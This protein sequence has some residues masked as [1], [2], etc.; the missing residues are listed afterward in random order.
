MKKDEMM[1]RALIAGAAAALKYKEKNQS[2]GES[3]VMSHVTK[4]IEKLI[5]EIEED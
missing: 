4:E 5:K 2:A 3:E 1:K